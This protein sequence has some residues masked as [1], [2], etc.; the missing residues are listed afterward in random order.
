MF[1]ADKHGD[2]RAAARAEL[3]EEAQPTGGRLIMAAGEAEAEASALEVEKLKQVRR[4]IKT[5]ASDLVDTVHALEAEV[6]TVS[7]EN[8]AM[9]GALQSMEQETMQHKGLSECVATGEGAQRRQ[10]ERSWS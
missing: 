6:A 8:S 5:E 9:R 3:S 10:C 4:R 2:I 7:K 1:E